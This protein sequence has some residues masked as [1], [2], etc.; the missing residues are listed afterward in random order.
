[1]LMEIKKSKAVKGAFVELLKYYKGDRPFPL[2]FLPNMNKFWPSHGIYHANAVARHAV[3]L[4]SKHGVTSSTDKEDLV[5]ACFMHDMKRSPAKMSGKSDAVKSAEMAFNRL[6]GVLPLERR[7]RIK[8]IMS[9]EDELSGF[10]HFADFLCLRQISRAIVMGRGENVKTK[11]M[12][13]E[14]AAKAMR[15][16]YYRKLGYVPEDLRGEAQKLFTEEKLDKLIAFDKELADRGATNWFIENALLQ[17]RKASARVLWSFREMHR[18]D[19]KKELPA[20]FGFAESERDLEKHL[21]GMG[22]YDKIVKQLKRSR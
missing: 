1:M 16:T 4:A 22:Y 8:R 15:A 18:D 2:S 17:E 5:I 21:I 11:E 13:H 19:L 7:K 6:E 9:G 12:S 3:E 20:I 10:M 14:N